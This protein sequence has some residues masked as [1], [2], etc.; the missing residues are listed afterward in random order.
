MQHCRSS[1][2]HRDG[3]ETGGIK[4]MKPREEE[5]MSERTKEASLTDNVRDGQVYPLIFIK[6]PYLLTLPGSLLY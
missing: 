3:A 5:T 2:G 6:F 1:L 4:P